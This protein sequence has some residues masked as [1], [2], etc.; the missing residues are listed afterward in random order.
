MFLLNFYHLG[1]LIFETGVFGSVPKQAVELLTTS[2]QLLLYGLLE[3]R[4]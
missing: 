4:M 3:G 1:D 2:G